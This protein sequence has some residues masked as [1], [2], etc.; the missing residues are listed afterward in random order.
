MEIFVANSN[1]FCSILIICW[2]YS[3][4]RN[5]LNDLNISRAMNRK[6]RNNPFW[7]EFPNYVFSGEPSKRF[8][9]YWQLYATIV[10]KKT[11][12]MHFSRIKCASPMTTPWAMT[13]SHIWRISHEKFGP[14]QKVLH[15][16]NRKSVGR[17]V[18]DA[19]IVTHVLV[20]VR[21]QLI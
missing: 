14:K 5:W 15:S 20:T 3:S 21:Q 6:M 18:V 7:D 10:W 9:F 13:H 16:K 17:N 1:L 19:S 12:H 11:A 4:E 8:H 2:S